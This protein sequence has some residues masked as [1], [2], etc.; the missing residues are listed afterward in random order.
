MTLPSPFT[1]NTNHHFSVKELVFGY[2][3]QFPV[4]D[5]HIL[6]VPKREASTVLDLSNDELRQHFNLAKELKPKL[7]EFYKPDGYT[8]GWNIA[9]AGGQSV[10]HAHLHII[11]RYH[12]ENEK[13]KIMPFGGLA[14]LPLTNNANAVFYRTSSA[15]EDI[16][17]ADESA[18]DIHVPFYPSSEGHVLIWPE[19]AVGNFFFLNNDQLIGQINAARLHLLNEFKCDGANIGWDVGEAAGQMFDRPYLQ[20]L[21][22]YKGDTQTPR[23]GMVQLL[24][25][26]DPYYNQ[27]NQGKDVAMNE[28]IKLRF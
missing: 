24:K 14:Q 22:R 12:A 18:G 17:D 20:V 28:R 3:N 25:S 2:V 7:D 19:D 16:I 15:M 8:V 6:I 1:Q 23:G 26:N 9:E 5:G 11:P 13:R 4:S 10:M 27:N 21:P